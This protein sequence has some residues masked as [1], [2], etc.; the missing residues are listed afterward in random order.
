MANEKGIMV[1]DDDPDHLLICVLI[2]EKRGYKVMPLQGCKEEREL[3]EAVAAFQPD[4]IFMDHKMPG[5]C[6]TDLTK[7]RKSDPITK[8]I[9]VI[10]F[11]SE[12]GIEQ[13]AKEAGADGHF[14]KPFQIADLLEI[15]R[16]F[17]V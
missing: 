8:S 9:P 16:Q 6:G 17:M 13:L 1:V 2:F 5:L 14:R 11:T 15:T 7:L 4:L 12:T 10:Y 3:T